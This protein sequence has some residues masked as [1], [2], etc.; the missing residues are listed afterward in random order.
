MK[1]RVNVNVHE[2]TLF[3]IPIIKISKRKID[4]KVLYVAMLLKNNFEKNKN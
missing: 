4:R 3:K 1:N 2:N